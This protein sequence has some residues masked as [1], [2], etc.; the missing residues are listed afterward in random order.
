VRSEPVLTCDDVAERLAGAT[1]GALS[2][3]PAARRHVDGC[4]RCQAEVVHQRR[5]RRA[6]RD[7]RHELSA[8]DPTLLDELLSAVGSDGERRAGR[9][10]IHGRRVAYVG[11]L[12]A[13]ATAA[14]VGGAMVLA[15]RTRRRLPLAG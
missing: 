8:P 11:G 14:G 1:D 3:E 7:L 9:L 10:S 5:L 12:A 6:L 4:L 15:N 2:L 13:A